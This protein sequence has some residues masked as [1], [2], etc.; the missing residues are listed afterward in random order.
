MSIRQAS[1]MSAI[2]LAAGLAACSTSTPEPE[3]APERPVT[4][5]INLTALTKLCPK[6]IFDDDDTF[7]RFY[8]PASSTAPEN[9][10]YQAAL[11][12]FSRSCTT[13]PS[14]DQ[15][16][17]QLSVAGRIVGGPKAKAGTYKV[18]VRVELVDGD[19]AL[20]DQVTVKEVA[21]PAEG[22]S[23]QFLFTAENIPVPATA[24]S[25]TWVRIGIAK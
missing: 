19:V 18:P 5:G 10:T 8:S 2:F 22:L 3:P 1:R 14:G 17:V 6:A 16:L 13:A 24:G 25:N 12:D 23:T 21:L 9:L 15:L 7:K 11:T 4:P 20:Y